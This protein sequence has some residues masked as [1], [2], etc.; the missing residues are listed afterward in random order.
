M[1]VIESQTPGD[2]CYKE[3]SLRVHYVW[4]NAN[5]FY[6][7]LLSHKKTCKVYTEQIYKIKQPIT[8]LLQDCSVHFPVQSISLSWKRAVNVVWIPPTTDFA[9]K[10]I[11]YA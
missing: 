9:F 1:Y 3:V 10:W 7:Q 2:E 4:Y 11:C 8:W 6:K 5:L